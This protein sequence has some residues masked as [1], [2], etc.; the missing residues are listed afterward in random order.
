[1]EGHAIDERTEKP[2]NQMTFGSANAKEKTVEEKVA[3][4]IASAIPVYD[5]TVKFNLLHISITLRKTLK[6]RALGGRERNRIRDLRFFDGATW[7]Q[8]SNRCS[9]FCDTGTIGDRREYIRHTVEPRQTRNFEMCSLK[10]RGRNRFRS[11]R[12]R[13]NSSTLVAP[14]TLRDNGAICTERRELACS[15]RSRRR[16]ISCLFP[17]GY[18]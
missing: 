15:T 9:R 13:P 17:R 12:Q 1:M 4:R 3:R 8:R 2:R 11:V 16:G 6:I 18:T 10:T 5:P 14:D 7:E